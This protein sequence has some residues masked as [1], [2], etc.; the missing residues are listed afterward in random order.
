M[1]FSL[2]CRLAFATLTVFSCSA[3]TNPQSALTAALHGTPAVGVVIDLQTGRQLAIVNA[4]HAKN[5]RTT[6]GSI[7]KPLFLNSALQQHTILPLTSVFCRRTLQINDGTR[8]WNLD[9]THPR[10]GTP[11]NAQE[12][13]AYSCNQYFAA[14]ADRLLPE[15][16]TA[17]L[18][19]YGLPLPNQP[20][21]RQQKQL[22]VLGLAGI[23]V[24]PQQIARAYRTL[25]LQW[26]DPVRDGLR[27]SVRFGMAHNAA[28]E[29]MQIAGKTG[30][31]SHGWFVGISQHVVL[32]VYLPHGNGADAARLAQHFFAA[33]PESARTLTIELFS[34]QTVKRLTGTP[35]TI[36]WKQDGLHLA[37]KTVKQLSLNGLLRLQANGGPEASAAGKWTITW[38]PEGIHVLL[39]LPSEDYVAAALNGEAAPDEPEAS[40]KAMAITIRTFALENTGRHR[41]QGFDLC[42]S[43]HC[44]SLRLGSLPAYV[45]RAVHQTAGETLW[46]GGQRAHVYYS[47]N[48]GGTRE[49]AA[50]VWPAERATYLQGGQADPYCLRRAPAAWQ[51]HIPL[52]RLSEILRAQGW[53]TPTPIAD[54]GIARSSPTGRAQLLA[55]TG[56]GAPATLSA[57]SLRFAVD[58]DLGWN[59]IRS[60]WYTAT[61]SNGELVLQGKGYGHGAGLCQAGAYEMATEGHGEKD[62][63]NFYFPGAAAGITPRDQ[64][65][66]TIPGAGWTLLTTQPDSRLVAEGSAAWA[67]AQ[68]LFGSPAIP[69]HPI[70]EELPTT[71]LFRQ[72]TAEPGWVL[73]STRGGMI[74]LQ[75]AAIRQ[76]HAGAGDLLHE[77]LHTLVEH[78]ASHRAPLW[79]REGLV[80]MLAGNNHPEW[81]VGVPSNHLNAGLDA[82]LAHPAT[83]AA[84]RNAHEVAARLT[85]ALCTR[86]GLATVRG[87]LRTGVPAGAVRNLRSF[88]D[89]SA[90]PSGA[91]GS[92]SISRQ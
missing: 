58:R 3:Q 14:L 65:W 45:A 42:D 8:T 34:T 37:N 39:T 16:T 68:A 66:Q 51:A 29:G 15:Q 19:H 85:T 38:K 44:Q 84:S 7:L 54:I 59:Q 31:T 76:I 13:L 73:A 41:A 77:F 46:F 2:L 82:E 4:E 79:L 64:G 87:F 35:V 83:A 18:E 27:D 63:L 49:A 26:Q 75:P 30:T 60:D 23:T 80:E 70:V 92:L 28:V 47:Q 67:K 78:E 86:Y 61:V 9:C 40:L 10:T 81:T 62:I 52:L 72:T 17:I 50:D 53:K 36:E 33:T 88:E 22:L 43:T 12:A 74:F 55:V 21:T 32:V 57:S 1:P 6:P 48:C 25:A 71:E 20:Q 69:I 89:G 56:R 24:S 90:P 5:D 11:F 91:S